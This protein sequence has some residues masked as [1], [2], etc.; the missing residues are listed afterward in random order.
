[1]NCA[2]NVEIG[3]TGVS[4]E[5]CRQCV[6]L[7]SKKMASVHFTIILCEPYT[8]HNA[9]EKPYSQILELFSAF[10]R[11]ELCVNVQVAI[12]LLK[13]EKH[14]GLAFYKDKKCHFYWLT[15]KYGRVLIKI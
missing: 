13:R 3:A 15:I 4:V 12:F 8:A 5:L 7:R 1:M 9:Q 10:L 11:K 6:V 14:Y 2:Q